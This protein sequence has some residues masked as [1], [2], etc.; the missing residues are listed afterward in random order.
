MHTLHPEG[1]VT[2]PAG[3]EAGA[4]S[5]GIKYPDRPDL[6]IIASQ[7]DCTAAGVFTRNAIKS[8]PVL[9]SEE[10]LADGRAQ[11]VVVNSGCANA[12]TGQRGIED[13]RTMTRIAAT[14]LGLSEEMVLA[15]GTGVIG[16]FLPLERIERGIAGL[17]LS[18]E[19]GPQFARAIMTTDTR[20][21]EAA[22]S[23]D[24]GCGRYSI[25]AA[26]K[27]SGM[28]HPNM[29]TLLAFITTDAAVEPGYLKS[30]LA[31]T[32]D[33]TLNMVTIDGDT[34]PSD[35]AF[36]LANGASNHPLINDENDSGFANALQS[37][38]E[39][40]AKKI[41][42]DGEGA[43]RLLEVLVTGAASE[44]DARMAARTVASSPLVKSAINGADPNW[45]RIVCAVGR[46][47]AAVEPSRV[48]MKMNGTPVMMKG[49]PVSFSEPDMRASL[50]SAEILV[51][52]DLA[53]GT[54]SATAWGCDLSR[55]YVSINA[56]Y[57]T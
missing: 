21:K 35:S 29:G 48:G 31:R 54:G 23:V 30:I 38:C 37:V 7:S 19:L 2:T 9:L 55:D 5:A 36:I 13:A 15:A 10:R 16:T 22:A 28:I 20:T 27:G 39:L 49:I 45:G 26:A 33:A 47:R 12:C 4:V 51:E 34:S 42:A 6:A 44:T 24:T 50:A 18:R 41:A 14:Q 53:L 57:T 1:H 32:V 52:V 43:T 17:A 3:F 11:A 8:A 56:S 25:G 46:S 40:L